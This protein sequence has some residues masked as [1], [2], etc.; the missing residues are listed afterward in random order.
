MVWKLPTQISL[1]I[2]AA[3]SQIASGQQEI[4]F[5]FIFNLDPI[6]TTEAI[7]KHVNLGDTALDKEQRFRPP[8]TLLGFRPS[9]FSSRNYLIK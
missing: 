6:S 4:D 3:T 7:H 9:Y 2:R 8:T 5:V 1:T